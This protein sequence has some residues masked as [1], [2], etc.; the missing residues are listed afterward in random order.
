VLLMKRIEEFSDE[1][2][3]EE[4]TKRYDDIVIV[5]RKVLDVGIT[6][7]ERNKWWKGDMDVC[8]GLALAIARDI[9]NQ[10]WGEKDDTKD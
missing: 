10:I 2:L 9:S 1:D 5:G 7:S 4:L 3:I 8:A 6:K